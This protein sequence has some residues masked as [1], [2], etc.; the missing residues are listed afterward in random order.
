MLDGHDA[1]GLL[2][3]FVL[4]APQ[5]VFEWLGKDVETINNSLPG[6]LPPV[7]FSPVKFAAAIITV[8]HLDIVT[9]SLANVAAVITTVEYLGVGYFVQRE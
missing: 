4:K 6:S 3:G 8:E 5:I 7:T 2:K 1:H 9:F